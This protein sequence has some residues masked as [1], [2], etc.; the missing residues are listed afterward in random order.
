MIK[1]NLNPERLVDVKIIKELAGQKKFLFISNDRYTDW[2]IGFLKGNIIDEKG[3]P[4]EGIQV[5]VDGI[6]FENA[7]TDVNGIYKVRFKIPIVKGLADANG[8]LLIH[9]KWETELEIKGLSYQPTLKDAPFRIYYNGNAGGIVA[10]SEGTLPP[11][12]T[13]K[14]ITRSQYKQKVKQ[15]ESL[16][17]QGTTGKKPSKTTTPAT[18]TKE[19]DLFKQLD[20]QDFGK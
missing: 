4:A 3:V 15:K 19:D 17:N 13:V 7:V 8:K 5:M 16:E 10:L 9:P 11:K 20:L 2:L 18:P 6:G 14:Q 12:I 1:E